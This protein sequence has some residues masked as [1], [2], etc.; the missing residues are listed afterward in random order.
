M[1]HGGL[2]K[3]TYIRIRLLD[4]IPDPTRPDVTGTSPH[5]TRVER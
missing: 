4:M 2:S 5:V 3:L 1:S